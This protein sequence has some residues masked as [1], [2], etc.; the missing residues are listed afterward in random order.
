MRTLARTISP[1]P[2]WGKIEHTAADNGLDWH[3]LV[4]HSTDVAAC[5][6]VLLRILTIQ[7]RLATL[8]EQEQDAVPELWIPRIAVH[9]F[10]HD[11][12]KANRGFHRERDSEL[13]A[14][15]ARVRS[16]SLAHLPSLMTWT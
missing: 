7:Q 8:A 9:A 15:T 1:L 12:G 3:S 11:L 13:G 4:D 16:A 2:L 5:M 10:L 6:E 14:I